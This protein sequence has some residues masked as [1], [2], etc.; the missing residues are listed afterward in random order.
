[1]IKSEADLLNSA[2]Q[3][4]PLLVEMTDQFDGF[5]AACYADHPLVHMLRE[6]I[7]DRPVVSIFEASLLAAISFLDV[8][9]T[10]G[11][12]TTAPA[13][14]EMLDQSVKTLLGRSRAEAQFTGTCASGIG[15]QDLE[16]GQEQRT[17][18]KMVAATKCLIQRSGHTLRV[19]SMG[20]VILAGTEQYV[21][22]ACIEELGARRGAQVRI[23]DQL[24]AGLLVL[25]AALCSVPL[26]QVDFDQALR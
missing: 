1:M 25:D 15:L 5:L 26:Q 9:S 11:I 16:H 23:V 24:L 2:S 8:G 14:E 6:S 12:V 3:C 19:V 22:K 4:L 13:Y 7:L 17:G 18:E 20:G 21:R 10:F